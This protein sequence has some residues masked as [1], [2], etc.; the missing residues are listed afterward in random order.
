LKRELDRDN[1]LLAELH[2]AKELGMT[3]THLQSNMTY[4]ELSI[5]MA[6]FS[7]MND[8]QEATMKKARS[9]RR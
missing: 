2:V 7:L 6:Y 8:K 9:G 4:A 3:L 5:W 1:T